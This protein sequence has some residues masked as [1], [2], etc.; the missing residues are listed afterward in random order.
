[1]VCPRLREEKLAST[2]TSPRVTTYTEFLTTKTQ[3]KYL[4][5]RLTSSPCGNIR[6]GKGW[7]RQM[8]GRYASIFLRLFRN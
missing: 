7:F 8:V 3:R 4:V 2:A 6:D 1:M 5:E